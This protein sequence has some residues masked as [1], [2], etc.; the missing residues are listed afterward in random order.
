ME[1]HCS[2]M[3][4]QKKTLGQREMALASMSDVLAM[5]IIAPRM[6]YLVLAE[7]VDYE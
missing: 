4:Y 5:G 2:L 7:L 1:T 3:K 6:S